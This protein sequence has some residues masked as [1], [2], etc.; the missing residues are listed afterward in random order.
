MEIKIEVYTLLV[1]KQYD[2]SHTCSMLKSA[3]CKLNVQD[4]AEISNNT[5]RV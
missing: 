1:D 2:L 3:R 5:K 4:L